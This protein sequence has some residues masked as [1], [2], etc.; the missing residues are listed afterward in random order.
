MSFKVISYLKLWQ[1]FV[2]Q[3]GTICAFVVEDI[4]RN[5]SVKLGPLV[6][7]EMSFKDCSY[8]ALWRPLSRRI[9]IKCAS[10]VEG[11]MM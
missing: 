1:P 5:N 9:G 4:M 2:Q 6:Q 7:K 11:I 8:L 10:L 3:I